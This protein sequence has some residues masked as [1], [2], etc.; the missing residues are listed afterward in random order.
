MRQIIMKSKCFL[1]V[2]K[3]KAEYYFCLNK[4]WEETKSKKLE[5]RLKKKG[6]GGINRS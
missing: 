6:G 1:T 4:G 5:I 3:P 2:S